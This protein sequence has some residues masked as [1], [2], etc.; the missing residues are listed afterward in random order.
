MKTYAL[1]I[2]L[3][4]APALADERCALL[5]EIAE[6]AMEMRQDNR[7]LSEGIERIRANLPDDPE[8]AEV[9]VNFL[10]LAYDRPLFITEGAK[11]E[12]IR[13]FRNEIEVACYGM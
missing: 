5:G 10:V 4:P 7:V 13:S 9:V 8:A 11:Q 12:S 1:M 2:A 3:M 6:N